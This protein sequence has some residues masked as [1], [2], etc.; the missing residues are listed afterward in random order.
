M[1][2]LI[3]Q[4][5]ID[6]YSQV[7]AKAGIFSPAYWVATSDVFTDI[8]AHPPRHDTRLY[9]YA[10]GKEGEEMVPDMQRA[11]DALRQ[12]K[13]QQCNLAVRVNPEAQHN[14]AAWR[15]EFPQAV[16]WLFKR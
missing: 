10:G 1:G 15:A 16:E 2:G 3:S 14:E 7:F 5:A 12:Q 13:F 6:H 8:A 4:Y 9:F 11:V